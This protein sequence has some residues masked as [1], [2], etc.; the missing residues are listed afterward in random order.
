MT[1]MMNKA[2]K[3]LKKHIDKKMRAEATV[4]V[5]YYYGDDMISAET[6]DPIRLSKGDTLT[7][8]FNGM[9]IT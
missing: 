3:K 1:L 9:I 5:V 4:S 6:R 2:Q 8:E 7:L